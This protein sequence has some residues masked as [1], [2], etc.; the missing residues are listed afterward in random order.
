M[1]MKNGTERAFW[2]HRYFD[3]FRMS[4]LPILTAALVALPWSILI[5]LREPDFWRFGMVP[6]YVMAERVI[7][8]S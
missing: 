6:Q 2:Q 3:L 4:W 8:G 7:C 5:Q 1:E